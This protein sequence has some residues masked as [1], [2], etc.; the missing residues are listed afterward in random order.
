MKNKHTG[1]DFD[2]WLEEEG[3]VKDTDRFHYGHRPVEMR[4]LCYIDQ[5]IAEVIARQTDDL[6]KTVNDI[7]RQ[8][9][10]IK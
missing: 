5:D 6:E 3:L 7:L 1:S 9:L 2:K 10:G 8:G 4:A